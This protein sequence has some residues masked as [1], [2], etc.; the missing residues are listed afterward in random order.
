MKDAK[1]ILEGSI[2]SL[3]PALLLLFGFRSTFQFFRSLWK[4]PRMDWISVV[5]GILSYD[6]GL[7]GNCL[8]QARL[9]IKVAAV[10]FIL[11]GRVALE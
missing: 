10:L 9:L 3:C 2:S 5:Y 1:S 11:P 4:R 8:L 6:D 7:C